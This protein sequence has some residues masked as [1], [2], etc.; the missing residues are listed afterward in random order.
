MKH[1][2]VQ[3]PS[4]HKR[5]QASPLRK[6]LV[7]EDSVNTGEIEKQIL[8]AYGYQV[9]VAHDGV[10]A[11]KH[12]ERLSYDLIVTDIEMPRMDGFTFVEQVRKLPR[13]ARIPVV[14]VTSLERESDKQRGLRVGA[15]AYITKGDFEQ[16]RF[17]ET[18][19]SLM[20]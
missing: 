4:G 11:L 6:I 8:Q 10:E 12:V 16:K 19:K 18:I 14:I 9:D 13:Y 7:V 20:A 2:T 17:V 1:A 5:V 15:N 3:A